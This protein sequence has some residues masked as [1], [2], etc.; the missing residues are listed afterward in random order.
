[1]PTGDQAKGGSP[2]RDLPE[3]QIAGGGSGGS[4]PR[5]PVHDRETIMDGRDSD[6]PGALRLSEA[7]PAP[8][9]VTDPDQFARA[10]VEVGLVDAQELKAL[11]AGP[12]DG[13]LGLAQRL[14]NA[15]KLTAYQSAA[16]YQG[17]SRG[18]LIG[19]YFILDKLGGGGMGIVFKARHR[20][21]GGA[22][23]LKIL[24]PSFARDRTAVLRFRREVEAARRLNHPNL[25]AAIE[26]DEDRGVHFLVMEYVQGRDLE[27][28]VREQG[29][30][31]VAQAI[32]CVIQAARGLEAA[33]GQ[34]I[35]HRDIKPSNLMLDPKGTVRVLD[36]GLAR[37]VDAAGPLGQA[38][39]SRLTGS[40]TY[41]G[42][43][44]YMAP[45]QA[46]DS[47]G[48]DHRADIYSLGCTLYYLVAGI[49][50]FPAGTVLKRMV[51]HQEHPAPSLRAAQSDVPRGLEAAYQKMMA[52][53]PDD[54]P[55]S[56]TDVIALLEPCKKAAGDAAKQP[57]KLMVFNEAP[58]KRA[59]PARPPSDREPPI[60]KPRDLP[61]EQDLGSVL[62]LED[63]AMD[64]LEEAPL[65]PGAHVPARQPTPYPYRKRG[66]AS[67]AR[68]ARQFAAA[69]CAGLLA[70]GG[71]LGAAL[72]KSATD[73]GELV[74]QIDDS[75]AEV[76][77][78]K[79]G[80]V[81]KILDTKID[82]RVTLRSGAYEL[83]LKDA[84]KGLELS[85]ETLT[86]KR[87][88]TVLAKIKR[89]RRAQPR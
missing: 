63:L 60:S 13:V 72:Y 3:T 71:L 75:D 69:A 49:A 24:P 51:A 8:A 88:Q 82:T 39:G 50:P 32:D 56:M 84:P 80:K 6:L 45:E 17:K 22:V 12:F 52:K 33:H 55:W 78:S 15:G 86:L 28:V 83:A 26:A 42:T 40:G 16:V 30:L 44:D 18:L 57:P 5:R 31:M 34:G 70:C 25:V 85:P 27:R 53:R 35:V 20:R 73:K 38:S 11:M 77:V 54:R 79:S 7:E 23:A 48:A 46:E 61:Q 74:L 59:A 43:V 65:P 66:Y 76:V 81:V 19:N 10:L 64:V 41:M 67:R 47:R 62:S 36:L 87:G 68:R 1:M 4:D 9:L 14:V 37:I 89:V 21:A 2:F 58:A 29:K